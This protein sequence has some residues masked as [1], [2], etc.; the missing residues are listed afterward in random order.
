MDTTLPKIDKDLTELLNVLGDEDRTEALFYPENTLEELDRLIRSRGGKSD[1]EYNIL[2]L[3]NCA[4]VKARKRIICELAAQA[5][6]L[7]VHSSF[8][9]N[10][11][12]EG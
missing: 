10:A 4:V 1:L 3:A 11:S 6:V 7:G 9:L 2:K 12:G 5:G 8:R